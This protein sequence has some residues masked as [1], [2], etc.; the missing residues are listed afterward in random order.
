ME[1]F[2]GSLSKHY[3][4]VHGSVFLQQK[5]SFKAKE[6]NDLLSLGVFSTPS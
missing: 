2:L 5:F 4:N 3:D 1:E 6:M